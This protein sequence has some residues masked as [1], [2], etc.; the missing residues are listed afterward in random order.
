MPFEPCR[1]TWTP[2]YDKDGNIIGRICTK[3]GTTE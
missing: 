3:C 1:H 2:I